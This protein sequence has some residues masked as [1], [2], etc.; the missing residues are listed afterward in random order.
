MKDLFVTEDA[1]AVVEQFEKE[2]NAEI[3][4]ELGSKV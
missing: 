2:K 3:E 1:N 4:G